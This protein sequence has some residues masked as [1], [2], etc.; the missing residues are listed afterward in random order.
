V[1]NLFSGLA[2]AEY[3]KNINHPICLSLSL[4]AEAVRNWLFAVWLKPDFCF[5]LST[6]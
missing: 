3:L 2:L 5:S 1:D 4:L 6:S